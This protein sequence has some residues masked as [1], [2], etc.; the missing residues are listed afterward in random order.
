MLETHEHLVAEY[1]DKPG[2][3]E[4][5]MLW[6]REASFSEVAALQVV[7]GCILIAA[8]KR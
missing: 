2:S 6:L 4:Q 3:L 1:D 7:G 8:V 5:Y